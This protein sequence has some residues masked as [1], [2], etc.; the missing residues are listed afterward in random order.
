M[1]FGDQLIFDFFGTANTNFD[2]ENFLVGSKNL[3]V[4]SV[5]KSWSSGRGSKIIYVWGESS[6]GKTH[7]LHSALK[8]IGDRSIYI[9]LK[10]V[11]G[12]QPSSFNGLAEVGVL[13]LDDVDS[14]SGKM[15]FEESLFNLFNLVVSNGARLLLSAKDHPY[16]QGFVLKD[17]IS[18]FNSHSV[19]KV[20]QLTDH[21]KVKALGMIAARMGVKA[22]DLVWTYILRKSRR[23]MASLVALLESLDE[24][25]LKHNRALTIP[26]VREFFNSDAFK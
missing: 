10:E 22:D 20:W 16:R 5:L 26:F 8:M 23:D 19:Y 17:L 18:R 2:F 7:L 3:E 1:N 6:V 24:Y 25:S 13:A 9:P 4:F 15:D 11:E 12:L 21:E 14:I